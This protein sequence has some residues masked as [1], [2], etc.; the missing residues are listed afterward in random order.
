MYS[1]MLRPV[2]RQILADVSEELTCAICHSAVELHFLFCTSLRYN[3]IS[4]LKLFLPF[5]NERKCRPVHMTN[6]NS[7]WQFT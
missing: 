7:F 4:L 6:G 3:D 2:S 5:V 1:G